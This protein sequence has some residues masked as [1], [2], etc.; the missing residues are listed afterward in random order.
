MNVIQLLAQEIAGQ[1]GFSELGAG[2][3]LSP[4]D[5]AEKRDKKDR[6]YPGTATRFK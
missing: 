2:T 6:E 1:R 4:F 3:V 5:R